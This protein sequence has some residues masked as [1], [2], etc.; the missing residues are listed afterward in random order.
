MV[1]QEVPSREKDENLIDY[2]LRLFR[3][4]ESKTDVNKRKTKGQFF[5]PREISQFMVNLIIFDDLIEHHNKITEIKILEPAAGT[6]TL[7]AALCEL[8]KLRSE[9]I[10]LVVHGYEIEKL[11]Q[12]YLYT[13]LIECRKELRNFGHNMSFRTLN[14]DFIIQNSRK[15]SNNKIIK[16]KEFLNYD[17]VISNPPYFKVGKTSSYTKYLEHVINGQPN[18]Y[19]LFIAL[20]TSLCKKGAQLV[21][22][23]PRSYCSGLYFRK[24]RNWF[25]NRVKIEYIHLFES[26][27]NVFEENSILQE[28]VIVKSVKGLEKVDTVTISS[29]GENHFDEIEKLKCKY[30]KI[31]LRNGDEIFIRIPTT[32]YDYKIL[33]AI[34]RFP[35][36]IQDLDVDISTGHV[37]P[38][39]AGNRLNANKDDGTYVPLLWM[40]HLQNFKIKWPLEKFMRPQKILKENDS[41][42]LLVPLDNYVLLKRFSTKEQKQRLT[43]SIL[44]SSEFSQYTH[45]GLENHINYIFKKTGT[46][47]E[48]EA[49]G[50]AGYLNS[51]VVN[52]YFGSLN[53]HTQV[54]VNEIRNLPFPPLQTI[55][56]IGKKILKNNATNKKDL[57]CLITRIINI[58]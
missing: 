33:S 5:T 18:I 31:V 20:S 37:V 6:G 39:R 36:K 4:Y 34:D 42:T 3:D 10:K 23:T 21:F 58:K 53:G 45:I 2:S 29:S 44:I 12:K 15:I 11:L 17:L 26:R 27:K 30:N 49:Y 32:E 25:L 40:N 35:D 52:N 14:F 46:L 13:V 48:E 55:K 9:T 19:Q 47:S 50:I 54:N 38:F 41:T 22:I 7:I 57:D 8:I 1:K 28:I 56:T 24:F 43:A 51:S 16:N